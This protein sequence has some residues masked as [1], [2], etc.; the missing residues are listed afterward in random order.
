MQ[1]TA[2]QAASDQ[3]QK[4]MMQLAA[5][6]GALTPEVVKAFLMEQTE[7][8]AVEVEGVKVTAEE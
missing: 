8:R 1:A 5:D 2:R 3:M 4:Q 6:H 7:Q